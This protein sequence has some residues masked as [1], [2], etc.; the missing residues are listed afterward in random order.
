MLAGDTY[1]INFQL[2]GATPVPTRYLAD[3]GEIFGLRPSGLSYGW[4]SDHTDVARDRNLHA[5]QRLDTL[6]HFHQNQKWELALPNGVYEVTVAVGDPANNDGLHTINVEG[7]NF[8][9]A[10]PDTDTYRTATGVVS[11]SDG[12]LSVDQGAAAEKATRI[13]FIHVVGLPGGPNAAPATPTITEPHVEGLVLN[14]GDV[15]MEAVGFFDP[16]G[17]LHKSTDW[18]IWSVGSGAEPVWQTLGITG[19]ERLHTHLGDGVF[20]NSHAGRSDLIADS[21]TDFDFNTYTLSLPGVTAGDHLTVVAEMLDATGGSGSWI[22]GMVDAFTLLSPTSQ[23]LINDGSFELATSGTQTSGSDW[24][25]NAEFD[26]IEPAAQFQTA[27]WSASDGNTGVWF[28]GFRGSAG[29]PV[30]ASVSQVVTATVSGEYTL[31]FDAKVEEFFP[32]VIGG[33]RVTISSDGTGGTQ[34]INLLNP[35]TRE[36]ELRVRFR[37]DAGSVSSYATRRFYVGAASTVFP[38]ELQ[39]V[40]DVPAPEWLNAANNDVVL[41]S[42]LP[43]QSELRLEAAGGD[44]LLSIRGGGSPHIVTNPAPLAGHADLRVV[45]RAGSNGLVLGEST[46]VFQ[47]EDGQE[48]T[49]Y[50]P[51]MTLPANQRLDLWVASEGSTYYGTAAQMEPDFSNL[52]RRADLPVPFL[53]MQ[54]GFVVEEVAGGFQLPTNI[55]FVP[56]PGPD[57]DDP[58][59]YVTELYGTIKVVTRDFTVGDYATGLL[60]FDP[61]GAFPGSGEQGLAGIAVDPLTGDVFATRVTATNPLDPQSVHHPQVLRFTST[62]GGRT[63]AGPPTVIRNMVGEN[64]GQ[65]HQISNVTVGFDGKLYVHMGDGF[66][67]T[68]AQNLNSYRGKVLRMNLNGT[69]PSDNP[70]YNAGDGITARDYVYAYGFRNPFGGA[71]RFSDGKHY[72]VENG[73]SID[74]LAQVNRGVNYGWNNSDASMTINAIYNWN[75]AHAPVNMTFVQPQTFGG[76]QY[77]DGMQDRA[78]VSES[79][80]TYATGPQERGKRIVQFE[81]SAGGSLISGPS[82]LVEYVGIGKGTVVGLATGPDGLYFTELYK[83][84]DAVT[85]IDAGARVF[86]VRYINPFAGDY[87]IN[88]VVD[89]NDAAVWRANYGSKLLLAADGNGNG[90]VDAADFVLWRKNLSTGSAAAMESVEVPARAVSSLTHVDTTPAIKPASIAHSIAFD[91]LASSRPGRAPFSSNQNR[92]A[93]DLT[94]RSNTVADPAYDEALLAVLAERDESAGDTEPANRNAEPQSAARSPHALAPL[95]QSQWHRRLDTAAFSIDRIFEIR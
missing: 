23:S 87:D 41:P 65:S 70:F 62:D 59:F 39:D 66:D 75:P 72:E 19:V 35:P 14:P 61:T 31:T 37:D 71:W 36:Y 91:S 50:L 6:I 69:A 86:R 77:P 18:E 3:A 16:D 24:V 9:N 68:T 21:L 2:G 22:S 12:R 30:D 56:N 58:L 82:T 60:N 55:A 45:V 32:D 5:D 17:N 83:D 49:V 25:M 78:F 44:L 33:F 11:V 90:A 42:S 7:V 57:A 8:F 73:P 85:P 80:P 88:G 34:T 46:L 52:A 29:N 26:G 84:L 54:P 48:H 94:L 76:S 53:A 4:S 74:R 47:D 67:Y 27:P 20:I 79:G 92:I 63:A 15:H 40:R 10:L 89:D 13:D 1:L 28:K 81:L 95:S 43:N 38:L 64:Q 93:A 51:A